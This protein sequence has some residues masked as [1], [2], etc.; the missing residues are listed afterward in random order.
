[1]PPNAKP[2]APAKNTAPATSKPAAGG[3]SARAMRAMENTGLVL[4]MQMSMAFEQVFKDTLAPMLESF[5]GAI[6]Q[7]FGG[8]AKPAPLA[9]KAEKTRKDLAAAVTKMR[10][11]FKM[12]VARRDAAAA[13]L[14][15]VQAK[16]VLDTAKKKLAGFPGMCGDLTDEQLA[17]YV[18][19]A[20]TSDARFG[21]WVQ[22]VMPIM[23]SLEPGDASPPA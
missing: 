22:T 9:P 17:G 23:Q 4:G 11:E 5:A 7:A 18:S 16:E 8:E 20:I 21:A 12:D 15:P 6:A 19:L 10:S 2:A 13:R 1:M 14:T 3:D